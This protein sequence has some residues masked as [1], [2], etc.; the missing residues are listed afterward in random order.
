MGDPG[1]AAGLH[2]FSDKGAQPEPWLIPTPS[3]RLVLATNSSGQPQTPQ[4]GACTPGIADGNPDFFNTSLSGLR[5][6]AFH[7][8]APGSQQ[9]SWANHPVRL[10]FTLGL[11]RLHLPEGKPAQHPLLAGG[12]ICISKERSAVGL[13]DTWKEGCC[14]PAWQGCPSAT[15]VGGYMLPNAPFKS[16]SKVCACARRY[17]NLTAVEAA[18]KSGTDA[19]AALIPA[20]A[21]QPTKNTDTGANACSFGEVNRKAKRG[22]RWVATV[23]DL[24]AP[25]LYVRI[26]PLPLRVMTHIGVVL[27]CGCRPACARALCARRSAPPE[28]NGP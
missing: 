9:L 14:P 2:T 27:V 3:C 26:A 18:A 22:G 1:D 4:C 5:C 13:Q 24:P 7:H 23:A 11:G 21:V 19:E 20:G 28:I 12:F 15:I 6:A 10:L 25:S 8:P 16:Y 17:V